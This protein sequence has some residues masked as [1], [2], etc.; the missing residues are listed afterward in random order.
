[1]TLFNLLLDGQSNV[2]P[3]SGPTEFHLP[4]YDATYLEPAYWNVLN[5]EIGTDFITYDEDA[6]GI[7]GYTFLD[8][9]FSTQEN[10]GVSKLNVYTPEEYRIIIRS[11]EV[12]WDAPIDYGQFFKDTSPAHPTDANGNPI[13]DQWIANDVTQILNAIT[14]HAQPG[15]TI[16]VAPGEYTEQLQISG[17]SIDGAPVT[18]RSLD[19]DN[20]AVFNNLTDQGIYIQNSSG[21]ILDDLRFTRDALDDIMD[22]A[23]EPLLSVQNSTNVSVLNSVFSTTR[24]PFK[25]DLKDANGVV[26]TPDFYVHPDTYGHS[27]AIF[28]DGSSGGT[29]SGN[30]IGTDPDDTSGLATGIMN[31]I[32]I[33]HANK[34]DTTATLTVTGNEITHFVQDAIGISYSE[35]VTITDN[36]IHT[37]HGPSR[38]DG[39]PDVPHPDMIQIHGILAHADAAPTKNL[40][41]T[42]NILDTADGTISQGIFMRNPWG[43]LGVEASANYPDLYYEDITIEGNFVRVNSA[44]GITIGKAD[45]LNIVNNTVVADLGSGNVAPESDGAFPFISFNKDTTGLNV[46]GNVGSLRY[47]Q[48][49]ANDPHH[50]DPNIYDPNN[51]SHG[52][53]DD[54]NYG[55]DG[56]NGI[57]DDPILSIANGQITGVTNNFAVIFDNAYQPLI[58]AA[59][60]GVGRIFT[61][62]GTYQ[63]AFEQDQSSG[64]E[65]TPQNLRPLNGGAIETLGIG[66]DIYFTQ[67][68]SQNPLLD[69]ASYDTLRDFGAGENGTAANDWIIGTASG[70]AIHGGDGDDYIDAGAGGDWYVQGG[71]GADI[72]RFES[73][74]SGPSND[75]LKIFDWE[76]G[77]DKVHLA[78]GLTYADLVVGTNNGDWWLY[79]A[80]TGLYEDRLFF[81]GASQSDIDASD[82]I[83]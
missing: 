12:D 70:D 28:Y 73:H 61:D 13:L 26:I 3:H 19:P 2:P 81:V 83:L 45:N 54:N 78:G 69:P 72:F 8:F 64:V 52:Q 51:P 41:I 46:T 53:L 24:S 65:P 16:L 29:I 20:P 21:I 63:S 27:T 67:D 74:D 14:Y 10:N 71:T 57:S 18:I 75:G 48:Y 76:D 1:M 66:S 11:D 30:I 82:F 4:N 80:G 7:A 6:S 32:G 22:N 37:P 43:E 44:H 36:Y 60:I 23:S 49:D 79:E 47:V 40:T 39:G 15:D 56:K 34:S 5:W 77:V 59:N 25:Q 68:A 31:G 50:Y 58:T 35:N 9:N 38:F 62:S 42:D 17:V 33:R 55:F